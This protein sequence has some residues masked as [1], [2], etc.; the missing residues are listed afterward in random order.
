MTFA[1]TTA[2]HTGERVPVRAWLVA[3]SADVGDDGTTLA[4]PG[5]D[6]RVV[7]GGGPWRA[8]PP[9]S[10]VLAALVGNGE[11]PDLFFSS[12]LRD[13]V[14]PAR[15]AVP[16]WYR[17]LFTLPGGTSGTT[18]AGHGGAGP[19]GAGPSGA[20]GAAGHTHL[21][22]DG[23]VPRA[24]LWLNGHLVADAATLAGAYVV[25]TL[26]V[27]DL[28]RPGL[29]ALALRIHP[30]NP[31][32]DLS[33]G[34]V[35][36]A[37]PPPD[38]NMGPWR[39][40]V[41]GTTGPVRLDAPHVTTRLATAPDPAATDDEAA[42]ADADL[43]VTVEAR[44]LGD[45]EESVRL[46]AVV[47]GPDGGRLPLERSVTLA[48]GSATTVRFEDR[49]LA[50]APLWW[51]IGEGEQPLHHLAITATVDGA[52]SDQAET[53]F[54]VR[55][56]DSE[57]CPGEGR[58]F[59]V[60]GRPV[61]I[62]GGGWSPDLLLR[63]DDH[64]LSQQL[65]LTAHLGLN[66]I[67]P[68]GKLENPEFYDLCDRLGIMV[69]PGWE[70]CNKWEAAAGTGG[71]RWDDADA[72]IAERSMASEAVLLRNH[73]SVIGFLIGSDYAPP[74]GIAARYQR[75]LDAAAWDLPVVSAAT[76]EGSEVTGPSGMKMTGPYDWVPP[77]YWYEQDRDLGG[78]MGFNSETS[79]G[80]TVLR[81]ATL[82]RML[83]VADLDALWQQPDRPQ[84]H[85]GPPSEFDNLRRF[86]T[87]LAER[88]GPPRSLEDFVGKAQLVA[89]ESVRAQFEA[90]ASRADADAP[91]TGVIYWMLTA[92]WPSLNWQLFGYDLDTPASAAAT[93]KALE[94]VHPLYAYDRRAVQ[95]L[96]RTGRETAALHLAVRRR[97]VDGT[98]AGEAEHDLPPIEPRAVVDVEAV[99]PAEGAEGAWWRELDLRDGDRPVSRN[100]YWLS[101]TDDVLDRST[102]TWHSTGVSSYADLRA[103]AELP[104]ARVAVGAEATT[105]AA[106]LT[107]RVTLRNKDRI[108]TPAVALHPSVTCGGEP[109]DP[110]LWDDQDVTLFAGQELTLTGRLAAPAAAPLVVQVDGFNLHRPLARVLRP[111]PA[112]GATRQ[113]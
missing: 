65:A 80:H 55:T 59:R 67:R 92:P 23:I 1:V 86:S 35:D 49:R 10:T 41:V 44:N 84:F 66:T 87:A 113:R 57:M 94:P 68:E 98:V 18:A 72:D 22:V 52:L 6:G 85:S 17:T 58:R 40:V 15:F 25:T 74:T 102:T 43:T 50:G 62:L 47:T 79:A 60:N 112:R 27:T 33:I 111:A 78:A 36:W 71:E 14:D 82:R 64:R 24:D 99:Q 26:D 104:R 37:Q 107:V 32:Q 3:S 28:V 16:W 13:H 90:F 7:T 46:V 42:T 96:N 4:L 105:E 109:L 38:D 5:E 110:V 19:G 20:G 54:G 103:L 75:A 51:P 34:W 91:A 97:R 31:C 76:A 56:V 53:T 61:Q 73:P 45:R 8:A 101:T 12:N 70:C 2:G 88:Y 108:G 39:D 11:Y 81:L 69:L 95:V 29:N 83:S 89:Y 77:S 63:H 30:G 106:D 100:V 93:R 48:P 9:R 21:R